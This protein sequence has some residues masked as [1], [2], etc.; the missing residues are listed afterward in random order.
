[1]CH[2]FSILLGHS[3]HSL[4][5]ISSNDSLKVIL[6]QMRGPCP[7]CVRSFD[8]KLR[9]LLAPLPCPIPP[10][11]LYNF[12]V[13][14]QLYRKDLSVTYFFVTRSLYRKCWGGQESTEDW[15]T[16]WYVCR[17]RNFSSMFQFWRPLKYNFSRELS[18]RWSF[19][20]VTRM[21]IEV[22]CR[23]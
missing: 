9:H 8:S 2:V 5:R 14:A 16:E 18:L 10:F 7:I 15:E 17:M 22:F 23:I 13:L 3:G 4:L 20:K 21:K 19:L 12:P 6:F 11:L 1:M